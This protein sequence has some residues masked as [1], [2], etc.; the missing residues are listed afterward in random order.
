M[1]AD[2]ENRGSHLIFTQVILL[3]WRYYECSLYQADVYMV[4]LPFKF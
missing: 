1:A 3:D 4:I 2:A